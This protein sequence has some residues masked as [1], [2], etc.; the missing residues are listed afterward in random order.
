[1]LL[2]KLHDGKTACKA[3]EFKTW[4]AGSGAIAPGAKVGGVRQAGRHAACDEGDKYMGGTWAV[5]RWYMG[6]TWAGH[7]W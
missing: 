7:G 3:V 2:L 6:D 1:M 4:E 5:H